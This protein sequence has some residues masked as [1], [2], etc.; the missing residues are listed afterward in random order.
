MSVSSKMTAIADEIR[1]LSGTTEAMGLDAMKTN[2]S[3]AN[4]EV[5]S[6]AALI[7]QIAKVLEDKAVGGITPTGTRTITENGTYD[8]T[9]YAS[10]V[11]NVTTGGSISS[12]SVKS[13]TTTNATIE[14]G[15]SD[16][17]EFF[18]YKETQN[19]VGLVRLHYSKTSG[20][21]YMYAQTWSTSS[22]GSKIITN[23]TTASVQP[24]VNGGSIT[25]PNGTTPASGGLSSG[26]TYKW[27]AIGTE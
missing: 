2:L 8:V 13:G 4:D 7:A 18:I 20:T 6:Q 24:T 12:L 21:S 19:S 22:Y 14:T 16:I 11:V 1:E 15:L 23:S 26:V 27:V 5:T 3:D 25:L 9:D 17:D 10:A